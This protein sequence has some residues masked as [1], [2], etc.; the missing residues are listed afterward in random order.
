MRIGLLVTSVGKFGQKSFY[1]MQEVGLAKAL[2]VLVDEVKVYKLVSLQQEKSQERISGCTNASILF[3]PSKSFGSNGIID[4]SVLDKTLDALVY[5]SDTQFA[6]P[7]VYKWAEKNNVKF[8]PYIGV[9]ESHSTNK[10]KQLFVNWMFN[11]NLKVYRNSHC[12]VKTPTVEKQLHSLGVKQ[13]T[14]TPVGLDLSL[15]NQGGENID[16]NILKKKYGYQ[17]SDKVILFIGRLVEEKQP[18]RMVDIFKK[19]KEKD[20]R[21][22]LLMVGI[23]PLKEEVDKKID[24]NNLAV[25]ILQIDK[26]MNS[27]IWE[28]YR[29]AECFV[30]LNQQEIFG[31]AIL[32]AMY[33]GCKVVAWHAPGPNLIIENGI[34]GYL[35]SSEEEM[36]QMISKKDIDVT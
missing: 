28:L 21:Y 32:E 11:R 7:K 18:L 17:A 30:N 1:N 9:I 16:C 19:L 35:V 2:S 26:I 13:I 8:F 20:D 23:G 5:F 22:K 33:Y 31:M 12:L 36:I 29:L 34:S 24:E 3:L 4:L 25:D 15:L 6:V 14:V 27:E 10:V